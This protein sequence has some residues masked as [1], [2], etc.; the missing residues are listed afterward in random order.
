MK[1]L[2][3]RNTGVARGVFDKD[4]QV[5]ADLVEVTFADYLG[6]PHTV[7][8]HAQGPFK[9]AEAIVQAWYEGTLHDRPAEPAAPTAAPAQPA[10][11]AEPAPA[12]PG[13]SKGGWF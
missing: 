11:A 4:L 9:T 1:V 2:S 13:S 10:Q 3:T 8:A 5:A 6:I 7:Y 12:N